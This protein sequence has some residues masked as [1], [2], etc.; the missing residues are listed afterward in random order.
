MDYKDYYGA[1]G[2]AKD[3][4]RDEIQKAYRKLARKYH[5]DLNKGEDAEARFKEINEAYQ[6]LSDSEKR[7]RYDQFGSA[8]KQSQRTGGPPPGFEDIFA[9]FT[10]GGRGF[11][12]GRG[13]FSSFFEMLFGGQGGGGGAGEWTVF[14]GGMPP[15][16]GVDHEARLTLSLEE[17][18]AG[19]Q[20]EISLTDG[21]TGRQRK[22]RVRIPKGVRPKQRIRL[23]GQGGSSPGGDARGNLY[24]RIDLAPHPRFELDGQNLKTTVPIAP[25]EAALGG[26]VRMATLNGEVTVRIPAGSSTGQKI[27]LRGKGYPRPTGAP[28]DLV[29]E[30]KIVVPKKTTKEERKL[31]E[32]LAR[33]SEFDPRRA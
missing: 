30:L 10:G 33:V 22:I 15:Q 23:P 18:A 9:S 27:R 1:L 32:E 6:V 7:A 19:G 14:G 31:F 29:A 25:W 5:P 26:Q 28:G 12:G 13:G 16:E 20:R 24:L 2:V 8:W 4:S 3:A 11:S 17:A 21:G